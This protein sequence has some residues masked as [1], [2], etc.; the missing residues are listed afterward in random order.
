MTIPPQQYRH[1]RPGCTYCTSILSKKWSYMEIGV[2]I[3]FSSFNLK[4]WKIKY[5]DVFW[6]QGRISEVLN[7]DILYFERYEKFIFVYRFDQLN[8]KYVRFILLMKFHKNVA[9]SKFYSPLF[10]AIILYNNSFE[11]DVLLLSIGFLFV[12]F[13]KISVNFFLNNPRTFK[14]SSNYPIDSWITSNRTRFS[15]KM[16]FLISFGYASVN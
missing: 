4:T 8:R 6:V 16:H 11:F 14:Y 7:F 3:F 1:F 12:K 15:W 9:N 10:A 5:V 2:F 13:L